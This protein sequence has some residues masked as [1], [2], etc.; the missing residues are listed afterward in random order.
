MRKIIYISFLLL[1]IGALYFVLRPTPILVESTI[2][3]PSDFVET[4]SVEGKIRSRTKQV[5]YAFATGEI[6]NLKVKVGDIVSAGQVITKLKWDKTLLVETP[7]SGVISKVFRE[8]AGPILR[9][10]P[11]FEVSNLDD[12]EVVAEIQTQDAIR[13]SPKGEVRILNWGGENELE[14]HIDKINRAGVVRISALGVE[15]EKT[16]VQIRINEIPPQ[17]KNKLGDTYHVDVRFI[18]SRDHRALTVPLGA[19]FK[20]GEKWAVYVVQQERSHVKEIEISKRND[21]VAL[22]TSG[23]QEG[24]RVIL[25]PGDRILEGTRVKF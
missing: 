14:A 25:F 2:L 22:V 23:L 11:I 8:S 21:R 10:E 15:E 17:L 13:L 4:L 9:G 3:T 16:E 1:F 24:D 18:I 12:L 19:L 20:I 5:I 7:L 6:E